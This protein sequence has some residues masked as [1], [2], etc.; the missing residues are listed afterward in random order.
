MPLMISG[1]LVRLLIQKISFPV[2]QSP[3][4][5]GPW[6]RHMTYSTRPGLGILLLTYGS[7]VLVRYHNLNGELRTCATPLLSLPAFPFAAGPSQSPVV[8]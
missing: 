8:R 1:S 2:E 4:I 7:N 3:Y 6:K 5:F